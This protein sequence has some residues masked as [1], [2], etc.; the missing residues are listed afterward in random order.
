M[1]IIIIISLNDESE[2]KYWEGGVGAG[3]DQEFVG[4]GV[5]DWSSTFRTRYDILIKVHSFVRTLNMT[6]K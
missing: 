5:L 2:D 4:L 3:G 1:I 6:T